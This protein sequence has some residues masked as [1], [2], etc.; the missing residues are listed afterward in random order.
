MYRSLPQVVK[1]L[2][3][4][5]AGQHQIEH[6]GVVNTLFRQMR[7]LVAVRGMIDGQ[8]YFTQRGNDILCQA[9]LVFD[10]KHTHR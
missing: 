10:Q 6:D 5:L 2:L 3:S 1:Y 7:P 4:A 8:S 9:L